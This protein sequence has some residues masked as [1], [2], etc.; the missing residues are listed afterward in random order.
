MGAAP[1]MPPLPFDPASHHAD[2]SRLPFG[3][4]PSPPHPSPLQLRSA[5]GAHGTT[6]Q[7]QAARLEQPAL[8][9]VPYI[10]PGP[11][12]RHGRQVRARG[13]SALPTRLR[14]PYFSLAPLGDSMGSL[15]LPC[16]LASLTSSSSWLCLVAYG[17]LIARPSPPWL[18]PC[19]RCPCTSA[20]G[21]GPR[22]GVRCGYARGHRSCRCGRPPRR[23]LTHRHGR[24]EPERL[25]SARRGMRTMRHCFLS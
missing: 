23:L 24:G 19:S 6:A 3:R 14:L 18:S 22:A 5:D 1:P 20:W 11:P 8:P 17:L 7:R 13:Q 9:R 21:G 4:P 12:S 25:W 10:H 15:H 16:S 2:P